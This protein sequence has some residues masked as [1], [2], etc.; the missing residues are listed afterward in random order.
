MQSF[1]LSTCNQLSVSDAKSYITKYFFPL[2]SGQH[3]YVS[4][5]DAGKPQ[6]EIKEDNIVK[7]VYFNRLPKVIQTYYFKE[8]DQIRTLTCELNKP[9]IYGNYINTCPSLM[10]TIKE[11]STYS[12]K[13]QLKVE[14]MLNFVKEIWAS[15]N[16]NQFKFIVK[17]FSNM[18][19]G[20]KNQSVLY[21]RG[22]QGIGKSTFTFVG[23][24]K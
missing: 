14:M 12:K 10:H 22:E 3:V 20:G 4:Y 7:C 17:W 6:Y 19:R 13:Q 1:N 11:Y 24:P 8:Y 15:G 16:E 21:L 9:F 18:S 2:S 5:D 23:M